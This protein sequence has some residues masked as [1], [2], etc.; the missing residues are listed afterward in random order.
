M[1]KL[2]LG[3]VLGSGRIFLLRFQALMPPLGFKEERINIVKKEL[4]SL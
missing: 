3:V 4:A 1:H 2:E